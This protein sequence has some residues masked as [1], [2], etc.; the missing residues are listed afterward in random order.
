MQSELKLMLGHTFENDP[1]LFV[2]PEFVF[3]T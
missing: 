2:I 1:V 3:P